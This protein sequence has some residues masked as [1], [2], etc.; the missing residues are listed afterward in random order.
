MILQNEPGKMLM[1]KEGAMN[2]SESER[3]YVSLSSLLPAV[4]EKRAT[5]SDA[6]VTW[7]GNR[8]D[9]RKETGTRGSEGVRVE[10]AGSERKIS[11][12]GS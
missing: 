4:W 11:R 5:V 2:E 1:G 6:A 12:R 8:K 10:V 3:P 9:Q 7:A